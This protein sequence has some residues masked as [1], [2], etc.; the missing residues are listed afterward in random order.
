ML[1]YEW[2]MSPY[3]TRWQKG[4][5]HQNDAGYPFY[6]VLCFLGYVKLKELF[7]AE[8]VGTEFV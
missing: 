5:R 7:D 2:I 3:E 1:F 4:S 8:K 6:A